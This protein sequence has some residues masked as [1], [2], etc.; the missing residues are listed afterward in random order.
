MEHLHVDA[1]P[2]TPPPRRLLRHHWRRV[3]REV[4]GRLDEVAKHLHRVGRKSVLLCDDA[5]HLEV[6]NLAQQRRRKSREAVHVAVVGL[7]DSTDGGGVLVSASSG[8]ADASE[9]GEKVG[10]GGAGGGGGARVGDGGLKSGGKGR[11]EA[12]GDARFGKEK[13]AGVAATAVLRRGRLNAH[14]EKVNN[15]KA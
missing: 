6:V 10:A 11:G 9:A 14:W 8:A 1:P 7:V 13:V 12:G 4:V 5:R 2:L 3:Q 15:R